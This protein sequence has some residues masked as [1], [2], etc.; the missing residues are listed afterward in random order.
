VWAVQCSEISVSTCGMVLG[1]WC[2]GT[3][4]WG[5][6]FRVQG[7]VFW[8]WGLWFKVQGM[9]FGV[10]GLVFK[11]WGFGFRVWV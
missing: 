3:E 10:S 1:V 9:G 11:V 4:L 6:R 5:L 8:V 7:L 2:L